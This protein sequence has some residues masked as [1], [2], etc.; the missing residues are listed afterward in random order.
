LPDN[1]LDLLCVHHDLGAGK[2]VEHALDVLPVLSDREQHF[3]ELVRREPVLLLKER[4]E[5]LT[6]LKAVARLRKQSGALAAAFAQLVLLELIKEPRR[7]ADLT[8]VS[9]ADE[10]GQLQ[11]V[12]PAW[13]LLLFFAAIAVL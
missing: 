10:G 8:F 4:S 11:R 5:R 13:S 1:L 9:S 2:L 3:L 6:C 7:D 12:S